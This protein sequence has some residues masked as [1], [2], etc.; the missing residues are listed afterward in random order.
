MKTLLRHYVIDTVALYLAS[1]ATSGLIF[2]EGIKTLLLAGVGLMAA[3]L[4][5]RP[6]INLLIL[7]L[8]LITFGLFKWVSS[9]IALYL[10]SLVVPGFKIG[11]FVFLGLPTGWIDIPSFSLNGILAYVGFSFLL[12]LITSFMHWLIK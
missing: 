6:L 1:T 3:S 9:A 4:V 8:N 2:A 10:V 5:V 11:N 12:S 7:P